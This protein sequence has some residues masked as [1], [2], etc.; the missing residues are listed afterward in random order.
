MKVEAFSY[1]QRPRHSAGTMEHDAICAFLAKIENAGLRPA[2]PIADL[3]ATGELVRFAVQGDRPGKRNAW[4]ILYLDGVPAGAFGSW[5]HGINE[6]WREGSFDILTAA[7]RRVRAAE[8][9]RQKEERAAAKLAEQME[10]AQHCRG[11]WDNAK[12]ADPR[13]P[14]LVR[15]RIAAD[16]L[17][18]ERDRLLVPMFDHS[19][20][21]WNLQAI[22]P[23]GGKRFA[24][25]G[26][27]TGLFF[28]LGDLTPRI[29]IG[30]GFATCAAARRATGHMAVAAFSALNLREVA[31]TIDAAFP[32]ADIV[33]LADDDAHLVDHPLVRKNVGLE[34]ARAAALAVGGRVALPPRGNNHEQ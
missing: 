31:V 15:K 18:Q 17:R 29:L 23:D 4:A 20:M 28:I 6:R 14:Y 26:R 21:L 25:G 19:G 9:R 34:A 1:K 2:E 7:E 22:G 13:H 30:E 5:K 16:G 33:M 11:R 3:L 10:A 32:G 27:Q 8:L 12:G 24:K